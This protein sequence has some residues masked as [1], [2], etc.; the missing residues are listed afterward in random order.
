[1]I[2]RQMILWMIVIIGVGCE[3]PSE[4]IH[5][6]A[7]DAGS[8]RDAVEISLEK[9]DFKIDISNVSVIGDKGGYATDNRFSCN[10]RANRSC[11]LWLEVCDS[12]DGHQYN[13]VKDENT[14]RRVDFALQATN[15]VYNAWITI[16]GDGE[17]VESVVKLWCRPI[18][19][20]DTFVLF[21]TNAV[22][23]TW[24]GR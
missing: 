24:I 20:G 11:E 17:S 2:F 21:Q 12:K 18:P 3:K 6:V 15:F 1:M 5:N 23:G 10:V 13:E 8:P 14:R 9:Q 16:D 4:L 19:T 7:A 22:F